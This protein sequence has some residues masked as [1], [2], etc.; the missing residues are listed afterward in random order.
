MNVLEKHSLHTDF[1]LFNQ[2]HLLMELAH[3]YFTQEHL[4]NMHIDRKIY[5]RSTTNKKMHLVFNLILF[6]L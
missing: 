4:R 2:R 3:F 6:T 1:L 5:V